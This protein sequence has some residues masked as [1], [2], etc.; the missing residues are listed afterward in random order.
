M[1]RRLSCH[2]GAVR[3]E[4][5]AA[6]TEVLECNCSTCGKSGFLSWYVPTD[7][8]RLASPSV[9]MSSYYWRFASEGLH[10]C[11]N[12]GTPTHRSWKDRISVNARCI[13]D[14]DVFELETRQIDGKHNVPGGPVPP[15]TE[16]YGV[17]D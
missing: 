6:L 3:L 5:N 17:G 12:C 11:S 10:F 16:S 1:I 13:E 15:L 14:I 8:V 7:A 9:G 4:V 2:C